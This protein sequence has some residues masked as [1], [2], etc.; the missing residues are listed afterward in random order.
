MPSKVI[1]FSLMV[2]EMPMIKKVL[3]LHAPGTNRDGDLAE[4]VRLAGGEPEIVP[5]SR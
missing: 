4:A 5:I 2:T 3:I 1:I